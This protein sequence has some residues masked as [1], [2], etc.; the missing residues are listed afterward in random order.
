[1]GPNA[2]HSNDNRDDTLSVVRI[3]SNGRV[4]SRR[5]VTIL[6]VASLGLV[7]CTSANNAAPA[8]APAS[9]AS[10]V[11]AETTALAT[12][13]AAPTTTTSTV[14]PTTTTTVATL[15][16][17]PVK[18]E[19]CKTEDM[20]KNSGIDPTLVDCGTVVAPIDYAQPEGKTIAVALIRYKSSNSTTRIGSLL[21]NPGGP[22]GSGR[23]MLVNAVAND[24][25]KIAKLHDRFD[26]IGFDPRGVDASE[27]LVCIDAATM[28][29]RYQVDVTPETP[30][31]KAFNEDLGDK[32]SA[33]CTT[34]YG[35]AFLKQISTEATARDMDRIRIAVGDDKLSFL[36]VSYGTF[37][38]STY[39]TLFPDKVRAFVLD[40]AYDPIGQDQLASSLTQMK[41]FEGAFQNWVEWCST[42]VVCAFG[43]TDV[44]KRWLALRQKLDDKAI[45]GDATRTVNQGTFLTATISSL[46]QKASGWPVLGAALAGA[47]KG[48]GSVLLLLADSYNRRNA[49]GTY[50]TLHTVGGVIRCA[51]GMTGAPPK[52]SEAAATLLR[53]ASPHFAFSVTADDF[54]SCEKLPVGPAAAPFSYSGSGPILVIGGKN[55]P[56]TPFEY[57]EKMT[58]EL[59]AKASLLTSL[60][61]GHSVWL[62]SDCADE[63]INDTLIDLATVGSKTCA[64]QPAATATLPSWLNEI[65]AAAGATGVNIDDLLPLL[66]LEKNGLTGRIVLSKLSKSAVAAAAETD[67]AAAG[68]TNVPVGQGDTHGYTRLVAG[69]SVVLIVGPIDLGEFGHSPTGALIAERLA[70]SGKTVVLYASRT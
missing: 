26:M 44:E 20:I 10:T 66:Q 25:T 12:T 8:V 68:W 67:L 32:M 29:L 42:N 33:A 38:G 27:G 46:Y 4:L 2:Q 28:D 39:A 45:K 61:E 53:D 70:G 69:K 18:W 65:P 37:L 22:G 36:G 6:L 60:G 58:K 1:M 31:E 30:E 21:L 64:A 23:G 16:V 15:S 63:A 13:T 41:G 24:K 62:E 5:D 11:L 51:S 34:K 17:A 59:G 50:D 3:T 54:G 7:A 56:A 9:T 52:D 40:G 35:E 57:A 47:E 43:P 48:D 49:D 14:P 19:A 55:D